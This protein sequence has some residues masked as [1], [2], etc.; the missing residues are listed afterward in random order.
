MSGLAWD[1]PVSDE[2]QSR[3][4][5]A[6]EQYRADV[7]RLQ[8]SA[9]A[10]ATSIWTDDFTF[11]DAGT[12]HEELR[13]ML[14]RYADRANTLGQ[15][16]YDTVRT[17]TEQEYGILLPPQG[18]I[19]AASPDRLI[20]Q[21]AGGSNHTD[22]PGLHMP[23]VIPDADG[24][25]HN[26]YGLRIDDLF[27]KSDNLTDWL[28]YIDRWCMSGTRMGIENCV[29]N[30]PSNP[31]WARVPKGR[32]CEF[33]VML[34]SRGYVYL[35]KE[36]A[37]LGGSFHDG[38]C[39]CAVVPSW[40]ASRIKG[41]NPELLRQRWQACADTV[42]RLTTQKEYDKY[43]KAFVPDERH[44]EPCSYSH[45]KRNIELAEARW[46]DRAW[47]NGGSEPPITFET[48]KLREETE[49]AHPQEIRTARRLRKHGIIPAFQVDSRPVI[50][51]ITGIEESIG[52]SD[53][54]GGV[55]IKTP[56]KAKTFRSV[57]GYLGSA[58]KK[59]DCKRLIIDNTENPNMSD[60]T[61]IEYIHRSNRFKRG[62]IYIL[63]KG[64][65]LL[66]IR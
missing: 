6:Y 20:W 1:S 24:T 61:L 45:W 26:D 13:N 53:W 41:Y 40:V 62:M 60:D 35:N 23:D 28:G 18:A 32:T 19:E 27:P 8:Q 42:S 63:D 46:R 22:Y 15:R 51:P 4:D 36:T 55:E 29:S 39:D 57:D 9:R 11:P 30:D 56:D 25:V 33:C 48:E 7:A 37:S 31:R 43:V 38:A 17:L 52:L 66:R 50:D 16:Y 65:S 49:I 54:A 47:L 21:L 5:A 12:R 58:S 2:F 44:P 3:L 64:Q 10:D 34:A 59:E 14:D